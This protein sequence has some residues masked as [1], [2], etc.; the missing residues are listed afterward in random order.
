MFTCENCERSFA[1]QRGLTKH[2][3]KCNPGDHIF[4]CEYC[5]KKLAS[6]RNMK[7]HMSSCEKTANPKITQ[8]E[9]KIE[10]ISE[11]T[12]H[13]N[14][15]NGCNINNGTQVV[16][17]TF[18]LE[19]LDK[20]ALK[21]FHNA[22]SLAQFCMQNLVHGE[23]TKTDAARGIISYEHNNS[24]VRDDKGI[25][26]ATRLCDATR[27]KA[28][29]FEQEAREGQKESYGRV[30]DIYAE[31]R[32]LCYG[33]ANKK[34][35]TVRALGKEIVKQVPVSNTDGA[36]FSKVDAKIEKFVER[37]F[38]SFEEDGEFEVQNERIFIKS[39]AGQQYNNNKLL[40]KK[41]VEQISQRLPV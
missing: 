37:F 6:E 20:I 17:I 41:I 13:A 19:A 5:K 36:E 7:K 18:K 15:M 3:V 32:S 8:L 26:L 16:N 24:T 9:K 29:Q 11:R 28:A 10:E 25:A 35:D 30:F 4:S 38:Q 27:D 31:T 34:H 21:N 1:Q 12:S 2:L 14:I 33:V 23:I 39:D 40:L 22:G